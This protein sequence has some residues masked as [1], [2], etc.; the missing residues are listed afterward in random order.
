MSALPLFPFFRRGIVAMLALSALAGAFAQSPAPRQPPQLD[1]K[2]SEAFGRLKAMQDAKD[3][4]GMIKMLDGIPGIKPDSYD[5]ALVLDTKAK[6]Y[7]AREQP[8]KALQPWERALEISD[9]HGYFSEGQSLEITGYLAQLYAQEALASKDAQVQR[10]YF[11]KS[12]HYFR[13]LFE[14]ARQP[15]PEVMLTYASLLFHQATADPNRIEQPLLQQAREVV[16]RGLLAAA[17]PKEGFY[18]MRL[19]LLQQQNDYAGASELIEL[20]LQGK[21]A[22]KEYWQALVNI[23]QQLSLKAK[24]QDP[25]LSREYLVRAIV[26]FERAQSLG[27]LNT[28]RENL[29]L[30]SLYLTAN[31]FAKGTEL[32]HEGLRKGT[33]ESEPNNWRLLGRFYQDG[34][35]PTQAIAALQE[36]AG[37]FPQ[38]GEIE[39]QLA[40]LYL[41]M[42]N[43][44]AALEHAQAA[45][46]KGHF[47]TTT[48]FAVYYLIAYFA[49]DL[50][51]LEEAQK[52]VAAAEQYPAE[53]EKLADFPRLK[54]MIVEAIAEH[55]RHTKEPAQKPPA[56]EPK[57]SGGG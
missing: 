4:D 39:M 40:H 41:Q 48:P 47:E 2:T 35:L 32:L 6:I 30:A 36:A 38:N 28:P 51:R 1:E 17:K 55:E 19:A 23:Y 20:L 43:T 45:V 29:S 46:Q 26:T 25:V 52:A 37:L 8:A 22:N 10:A 42:E 53:A 49:H 5:E 18:Q 34:N 50:G 15:T 11:A 31:Q 27:F 3:W 7:G 21:P 57:K 54:A 33:I 16:D 13:R 14:K 24:E 9:R 56:T 44:S 12:L